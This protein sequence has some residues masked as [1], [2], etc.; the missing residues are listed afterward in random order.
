MAPAEYGDGI[1][2]PAGARYPVPAKSAT[3]WPLTHRGHAQR[4]VPDGL[5]LRLGAVPRSRPRPDGQCHAERVVQR[6]RA[7]GRCLVRPERHRHAGDPADPFAY[8]TRRP[9]PVR[10]TR[11]SRST[12]SPPGST[13]RWSTAPTPPAAPPLRTFVGGKLKV[14]SSRATCC[15]STPPD[16]PT[17]TTPTS[18]AGNQLFLAGDVR[19]NEN[20]ELTSLQ[21]LFVREHNRLADADRRRPTRLERRAIYQQ[22]RAPWSIAEIQAI[23]YNEWLPALLGTRRCST[24]PRLQPERQ[25]R[26]RQRVLDRRLPPAQHDQRRRRV[27]RQRRRPITFTYVDDHGQDGRTSM[28]RSLWPTPS[29]TRTWSSKPASTAS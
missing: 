23:T 1:S 17:P 26:H 2:T 6:R 8:S 27:L 10:R 25:S 29:S 24:L 28:A 19:A 22:A 7:H 3:C 9:A 20:I 14:T 18:S 11:G 16:W 12:R 21:T 13:A 5:H 15:R 4:Q